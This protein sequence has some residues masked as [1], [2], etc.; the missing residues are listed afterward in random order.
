MFETPISKA[1]LLILVVIL[2]DTTPVHLEG[3]KQ[4]LG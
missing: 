1:L 3:G 4:Q 2:R